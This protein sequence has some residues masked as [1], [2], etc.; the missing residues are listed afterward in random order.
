MHEIELLADE[1]TL[2]IFGDRAR[3]APPGVA[4]GGPAERNVVSY[5]D[6]GDM[7]TPPLG[8]KLAAAPFRKGQ[9]VRVETP[10]GGGFGDPAMRD[11]KLIERDRLLGYTGQEASPRTPAPA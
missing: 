6:P 9:R 10:G 3:F 7:Q 11:P 8:A 1:A 5:G 4:G 2:T